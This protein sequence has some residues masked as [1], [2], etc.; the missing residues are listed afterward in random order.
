M[1]DFTVAELDEGLL[2][3]PPDIEA[4]L[5]RTVGRSYWGL[6]AYRK[7]ARQ[8]RAYLDW[9]EI[10]LGADHEDVVRALVMLSSSHSEVRDDDAALPPAEAAVTRGRRG[11]GSDHAATIRAI[12]HLGNIY[13]RLGRLDDSEPLHREAIERA[14]AVFG[15][16][17]QLTANAIFNLSAI[18]RDRGQL[19]EAEPYYL[20]AVSLYRDVLDENDLSQVRVR[21]QL[22]RD[23]YMRQRRYDEAETY[24]REA[25]TVAERGL[26]NQHI[27]TNIVR[28][29]LAELLRLRGDH[30]QAETLVRQA[31][32]HIEAHRGSEDPSTWFAYDTLLHTLIATDRSDEAR[33]ILTRRA[34]ERLAS[35]GRDYHYAYRQDWIGRTLR[36]DGDPEAALPYLL[37]A[38]EIARDIYDEH[39]PR[40][41]RHVLHLLDLHLRRNDPAA[42]R[43]IADENLDRLA[44]SVGPTSAQMAVAYGDS[45]YYSLLNGDTGRAL[46]QSAH[47]AELVAADQWLA[48]HFARNL[49]AQGRALVELGQPEDAVPILEAAFTLA[50]QERGPDHF[51]AQDA[52]RDLA[53]ALVAI[54]DHERAQPLIDLCLAHFERETRLSDQW[55]AAAAR[56]LQARILLERGELDAAETILLDSL[57]VLRRITGEHRL[58]AQCVM[59]DLAELATRRNDPAAA[60]AWRQRLNPPGR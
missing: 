1:L 21:W 15:R 55:R 46:A 5:R 31:I 59:R 28:R 8:F 13:M 22:A 38:L 3:A 10:A 27:E 12:D 44:Q 4:E 11:L 43:A 7:S 18:Y 52:R 35:H 14:T 42:I 37:E 39:H 41:R 51:Y 24:Y 23:I 33:S 34:A 25:L 16:D 17:H 57:E 19:D 30:E 56:R 36:D 29:L 47:A 50:S 40:V 9:A 60:A 2:S 53:G 45:A 26:G 58:E 48:N 20:E 6:G 32:P 49:R 54:G